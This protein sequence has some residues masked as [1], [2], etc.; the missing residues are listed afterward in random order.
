MHFEKRVRLLQRLDELIRRRAT[1][2]YQELAQRLDISPATLYRQLDELKAQ[3]APIAY[4]RSRKV[5]YYEEDFDFMAF[6]LK[7]IA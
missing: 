3:G 7:K 6:L 4:N 2:N 1:G 5:F